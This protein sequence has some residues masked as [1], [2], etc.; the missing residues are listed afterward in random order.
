MNSLSVETCRPKGSAPDV[1]VDR[2]T[3]YILSGLVTPVP[4][5]DQLREEAWHAFAVEYCDFTDAQKR[6]LSYEERVDM[7][8]RASQDA[9][10]WHQTNRLPDINRLLTIPPKFHM[11]NVLSDDGWK[12]I[13]HYYEPRTTS[14]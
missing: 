14:E 3:D 12:F 11:P 9:Y 1:I 7:F 13:A 2:L 8:V 5:F 10:D 4:P 6:T